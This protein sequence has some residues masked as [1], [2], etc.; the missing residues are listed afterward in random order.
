MGR[1]NLLADR[2]GPV[3]TNNDRDLECRCAWAIVAVE[4]VSKVN[5]GQPSNSTVVAWQYP[6][7][8]EFD[9]GCHPFLKK[10]FVIS[11]RHHHVRRRESYDCLL[12]NPIPQCIE[13]IVPSRNLQIRLPPSHALDPVHHLSR[14]RDNVHQVLHPNFQTSVLEVWCH[15]QHVG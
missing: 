12:W 11:A 9:E 8:P 10:Q 7:D 14:H 5:S 1:Y 3:S 15:L 6:N 13:S 2:L 4:T